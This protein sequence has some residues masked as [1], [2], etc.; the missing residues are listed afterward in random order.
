MTRRS[1]AAWLGMH[2][3]ADERLRLQDNVHLLLYTWVTGG[4]SLSLAHARGLHACPD[5]PLLAGFRAHQARTTMLKSKG[6][7]NDGRVDE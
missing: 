4:G 1:F 3:G 2:F 6:R 7:G 5:P